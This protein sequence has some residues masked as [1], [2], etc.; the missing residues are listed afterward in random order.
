MRVRPSSGRPGVMGRTGSLSR[1]SGVALLHV[2]P[3]PALARL[4]LRSRTRC[5]ASG[6]ERIRRSASCLKP[7][8]P[9][10]PAS[11]GAPE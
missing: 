5:E 8:I 7:W 4:R 6:S 11:A 3:S 9:G 10:S 1:A 2:T